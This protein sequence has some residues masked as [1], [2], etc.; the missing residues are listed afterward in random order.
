MKKYNI[1]V[2]GTVYEV[3]VEEVAAGTAPADKP[4]AAVPVRQAAPVPAAPV[5]EEKNSSAP[6]VQGASGKTKITAPMPGNILKV[7][8]T[9]GQKIKKGDV[10][11]L[12]EAMKM[13]NEIVAPSDGTVVS[14]HA[15]QGTGVQ[16]GELLFTI[17]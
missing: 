2:N 16:T 10:M 1:T 17:D 5:K 12:L 13:E 6:A 15:R 11:C 9:P 7:N 4:A 14:V 3:E 8:V